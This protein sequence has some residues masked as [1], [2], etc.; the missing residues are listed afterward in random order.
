MSNITSGLDH[1]PREQ[2]RP[3]RYHHVAEIFGIVWLTPVPTRYRPCTLSRF[4][5]K[6]RI[7]MARNQNQF[8]KFILCSFLFSPYLFL[9]KLKNLQVLP[10]LRLPDQLEIRIPIQTPNISYSPG[11]HIHYTVW[12]R[13]DPDC[14]FWYEWIQSRF[15]NT[16]ISPYIIRPLESHRSG[17]LA[18]SR[19]CPTPWSPCRVVPKE[20]PDLPLQLP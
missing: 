19:R 20:T 7:P 8:Y 3:L 9:F 16:D 10:L 18:R 15:Q 12:D 11:F 4:F 14:E 13:P 1:D 6:N 17:T 5:R 2:D